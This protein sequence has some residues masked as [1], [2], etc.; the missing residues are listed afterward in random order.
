M[1]TARYFVAVMILVATPPAIA[2]WYVIH[3][4]ARVW[5]RVGPRVAYLVLF[6]PAAALGATLAYHRNRL[7]GSDL[8][9]HPPLIGLAMVAA[10]AGAWIAR[11]RRKLLTERILVGVPELSSN[12]KGQLLTEGIY[13]RTRNPRYL[14][15]LVFVLA[16]V[17]FANYAGTWVL[18]VLMFP[19]LHVVVL[20]E[21]RELRDRFG[22]QYQDYCRRVP[23]Y[24]PRWRSSSQCE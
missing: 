22:A 12:D 1:P 18:F 5:R 15:T 6:F 7:L 9:T 3:P 21:E 14:E 17:S 20:L 4:L 13:G 16:Y 23:R 2:L 19:A 10:V 8:G 11:R 24:L